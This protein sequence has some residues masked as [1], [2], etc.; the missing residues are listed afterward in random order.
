MRLVI[1]LLLVSLSSSVTVLLIYAWISVADHRQS[2]IDDMKG[3]HVAMVGMLIE[4]METVAERHGVQQARDL[5]EDVNA[6]RDNVHLEWLAPAGGSEIIDGG[7]TQTSI[8]E[9]DGLGEPRLE[10]RAIVSIAGEPAGTLLLVESSARAERVVVARIRRLEITGLLMLVCGTAVGGLAGVFLV[11]GRVRAMVS[12]A[13]RVAAGELDQRIEHLGP[14]DELAQLG[15]E[16]NAMT[17]RLG[18][19][20]RQLLEE[21]EAKLRALDQLRHGERLITV[22]KLAAGFAHELGTPLNVVTVSAKMIADGDAVGAEVPEYAR[23][24]AEQGLRMSKILGE[25]MAFARRRAP[26]RVETDLRALVDATCKLLTPLADRHEVVLR[27]TGSERA[28]ARIDPGQIQQVVANLVVN[29]VHASPRGAQVAVH[30]EVEARSESST[31]SGAKSTWVAITVQDRG[32]GILPE[33]RDRVFEPFFTTKDVG[34]G[35]GLGLSVAYGLVSE[36]GGEIEVESD[37]AIGTV[38][39]VRLPTNGGLDATDGEKLPT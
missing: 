24:I 23:I 6:R 7:I 32:E 19:A 17:E 28:D 30:V 14:D 22:G 3:D 38:F 37:A 5:V 34:A 15:R 26:E 18:E 27:V 35:T 1:S 16:L 36:H 4:A 8:A 10:T 29:A 11:A 13:R 9:D 2:W 39:H 33:H 20:R 12:Q 25:L 31:A 21:T